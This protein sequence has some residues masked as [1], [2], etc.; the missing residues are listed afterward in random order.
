[1]TEPSVVNRLRPIGQMSIDTKT[2]LDRLRL[3]AV[4]DL[5][6]YEELS[7]LID[8]DV[9]GKARHCL[10]SARR[11]VLRK[12]RYVFGVILNVGLKRLDDVEIV[13]TGQSAQRHSLRHNRRSQRVL[14][15]AEYEKLAPAVQVRLNTYLTSMKLQEF[16]AGE[17][18][19]KK[20]EA[21]V[22]QTQKRLPLQDSLALFRKSS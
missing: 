19:A 20:I 14:L 22:M 15:A 2:L 7:K 17:R 13:N 6:S 1:M 3:A 21:A 12:N 8:R 9:Q 4:G 5:L 10:E 16:V 18:A 11:G